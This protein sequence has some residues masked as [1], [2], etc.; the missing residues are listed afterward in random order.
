M[1]FDFESLS[2]DPVR[3]AAIDMALL[4]YD[5]DRLSSDNPYTF[6]ELLSGVKYI[7]FDIK[8]QIE[9]YSR[10]ID[11]DTI[12][13]WR[14]QSK[15]AQAVLEPS[16]QDRSITTLSDFLFEHVN[17]SDLKRYYS[18]GNTFDPVLLEALLKVTGKVYPFPFWIVRDTRSMI[19]GMSFGHK[20]KNNFIPEGLEDKATA[21]DAKHDI[22][23]DVMRMQ[24]LAQILRG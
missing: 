17:F 24:Y 4:C 12:M 20:I 2:S 9:V 8:E 13:W 23:L 14:R 18:R 10:K 3:A 22:V 16:D 11:T 19:D 15:E 21:H 7:K 5:E 1:I 6:E